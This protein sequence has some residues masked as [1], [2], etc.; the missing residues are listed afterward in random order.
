MSLSPGTRLGPYEV[1]APLGAGGMGEVHRATDT[2]LKRQVALKI[3]PPALAADPDRLARF[4]REAEVLASLNHPHIAA[5]YGLEDGAGVKALVMELVEGPTLADRIAQGRLPIGEALA[6]ARQIAEALEAAHEQGIVHRDLK[7]AN[8]KVREDGTVKVLDFGLAKLTDAGA[9]V[10]GG[11]DDLSHSP[12]LTSPAAMTGMGVILGT[13]AYMSP[14]Q[15]RGRP[16]DKRTDIWAFGAVLYEMLTGARP[17]VGEDV[18][19][20]IAEV[21][22]STP[23][24]AALPPEVPPHVVTLVQRCLEK[25]RKARIGDMAVARFLLSEHA[26]LGGSAAAYPAGPAAPRLRRPLPWMLAAALAGGLAGWLFARR[27][28]VT[29]PVARL[30]MGLA[31]ADHL[32]G[33]IASARPSRTAVAIAPDGRSLVFSG[34]RGNATQLYLRRLDH[35]DATPVTGSDGAIAPFFSP[36][37][38]WIGFW[39]D[40]AIKKVPAAGGPPVTVTEMPSGS[41]WGASWRD[42]G[43]IF[44]AARDGIFKVPA[45]GGTPAQVTTPNGGGERHLLPQALPGG[46]A[47]LFTTMTS[48]DWQTAN[49][50]AQSLDDGERRVLVPGGA[51]ARYVGTGHLVYMK[52]GTLM[53]VAFDAR[54]RETAGAP[55]ALIEGVMQGINAPNGRDETGAGQFAVSDS[56]TLVYAL[57]GIGPIRERALVSVDRS[58]AAQPLAIPAGPYLSP[59]LSPDGRRIAVH[60]RRGASRATDIWVYDLARGVPTRLTFDSNNNSP[61]WSPDGRRLVYAAGNLYTIDADGSGQPERLTSGAPGQTPSSWAPTTNAI[62][63]MQ[64]PSGSGSAL[65]VL[66]MDGE[67]QPTLFLESRFNLI[68][69][70]VSPDGR[71]IAYVSNES[72]T[73]EVYVQPY[74]GPGGKVR[75]STSGGFEPVWTP[76]GREILYR[77]GTADRQQFFSVSIR[78]LSPFRADAPRLLF[79]AEPG[80]YDSTVPTRA[81]DVRAD[82]QRFV[83]LRPVAAKDQPVVT[84]HVVLNWGAELERLAPADR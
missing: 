17:F 14:E 73:G 71:W 38:R 16:V 40:N 34:I 51:D 8:V 26:A 80:A 78:S 67:R 31:P 2:R 56:G 39:A 37:G 59:R 28:A 83:L 22:K 63:Y 36:D 25:D 48:E 43:T 57:G 81:W 33:S 75:I 5:V 6:I 65:F 30:Q 61:V 21:V 82:G 12:T 79:E 1:L 77:S 74:P 53:A 41:G 52:S 9:A 29:P 45:A 27:P 32:V 58:G 46:N 24:W 13:A 62:V 11:R 44:F 35:A 69:P 68:H 50:V 15:A 20:M 23:N 64:R 19:D 60:A 3:L 18:T 54:S 76:S 10:R 49:V 70:D 55:V 47:L 4:Q 84:M 72:G 42:D 66:P 7:P